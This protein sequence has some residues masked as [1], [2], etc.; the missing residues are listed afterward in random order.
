[1]HDMWRYSIPAE[2]RVRSLAR[3]AA[4]LV[5]AVAAWAQAEPVVRHVHGLAF[6]A[7]GKVLLL[8][9]SRGIL[10]L[11][12]NAWWQGFG[13]GHDIKGFSVTADAIYASGHPAPGM[14]LRD[15]LGLVR[16]T[17]GGRTWQALD[18]AAEADFHIVAAGFRSKAVYVVNERPNSKMPRR[19]LYVTR[20]DARSWQRALGGGLEGEILCLAA[21]P[22]DPATIAAGTT[23]GLFVSRDAG[24]RFEVA[25][26]ARPVSAV[27]FDPGGKRIHYAF[28]FSKQ[29]ISASLQGKRHAW[30][31]LPLLETDYLVH[32][33]FSP[34]DPRTIAI[35]TGLRHIFLSV[36]G[37]AVWD[38]IAQQGN[39]Q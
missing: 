16:S 18:L 39:E 7:D 36:D 25:E 31:T 23:A 30:F 28:Y 20:D 22:D 14:A 32:F 27:A 3:A 37:G 8:P 9:S 35:T 1:M 12:D 10:E 5:F 11:R 6:A 19:G 13:P 29:L 21:H 15:P 26:H 38:P 2:P 4:C 34:G 33:A 17:D 24:N